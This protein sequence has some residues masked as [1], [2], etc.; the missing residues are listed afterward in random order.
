M[1]CL[2]RSAHK[3]WPWQRSSCQLGLWAGALAIALSLS[4]VNLLAAQDEKPADEPAATEPAATEPAAGEAAAP[5]APAGEAPP[6]PV[7]LTLQ[8]VDDKGAPVQ[9]PTGGNMGAAVTPAPDGKGDDPA[10]MTIPDLWLRVTHNYFSINFVWTLI[11][12]FLVMFM[13]AGF[14]CVE[15]G[16]C[17]ARTHR[18][19]SR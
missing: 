8:G 9:D 5:E 15:T 12:G 13:Q 16:L 14:A 3:R 10:K 6:N 19:R 18:T 17:R 2:C 1:N 4:W 7:P 11:T